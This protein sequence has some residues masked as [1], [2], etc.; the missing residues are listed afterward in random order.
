[1]V[2]KI[3]KKIISL[4]LDDRKTQ[5]ELREKWVL[6]NENQRRQNLGLE[7]F[8]SKNEYDDYMD[9]AASN[10]E[11]KLETDFVLNESIN[12]L[13]DYINFDTNTYLAEAIQ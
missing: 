12:I 11:I 13:V 9:E 2:S 4:N 1:M 8:K 5:K 10:A 7:L 3:F 6:D